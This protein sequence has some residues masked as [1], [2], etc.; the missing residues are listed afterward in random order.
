MFFFCLLLLALPAHGQDW[1]AAKSLDA[2]AETKNRVMARTLSMTPAAMKIEYALPGLEVWRAENG[3]RIIAGKRNDPS[4]PVRP[5]IGNTPHRSSPGLPVLPVVPTRLALP[6]GHELDAIRVTPGREMSLPG[7]FRVAHGQTSY[8]LRPGVR[9]EKTE[10]NRAV[11]ESD[12]PFPGK[13]YDIAG[14]HKKRGVSLLLVNLHPVVYRPQSG[15]L[16]W[17]DTM[18]VTVTTRPS[19]GA[20]SQTGALPYK[21]AAAGQLEGS[22]EN[23]EMIDSYQAANET[24]SPTAESR[25]LP[26]SEARY[27]LITSQ[28]IIDDDTVSPTVADFMAHRQSQ[29]LSTAVVS[30][31]SILAEP[32][33][34][35]RDDAETLRNFIID[36]YLHRNTEYVL[37]GGDVNIIPLRQLRCRAGAYTEEI[38]SD[39]YYQ[40][41]DGDFNSDGDDYWGEPTDGE[42]GGDVDLMAEIHVGRASAE[43][44]AELSN[45]FY[46]TM[47]YEN[48]AAEASY[49]T[50]ALMAGEWLGF[51][52]ISEYGEADLEEIRLGSSNHDYTTA[53][54]AAFPNFTVD[55]LYDSDTYEWPAGDLIDDIDSDIY[56]IIVHDGHGQTYQVMK[57]YLDDADQLNNTNP[58]FGYSQACLPGAF[59][60]DC[61]AEHLTTST[62]HGMFAGVYNSR[63]GW[64]M[65]N[66]TD[67]AS[68]RLAR[69]FWDACFGEYLLDLGAINTDSHEDNLWDISDSYV[70]WCIYE[71]NLL[72][73][74]CTVLRGRP[75][76]ALHIPENAT[77]GDGRLTGA[78]TVFSDEP[79]AA[80]LTVFLVSSDAAKVSVPASV[81]LLTGEKEVSFDL[82]VPDDLVCDGLQTVTITA[83]AEGF[84]AAGSRID[85]T[86]TDTDIDGDGLADDLEMISCTDPDDADTDD[87]GILDGD[88]DLNSNGQ[89]D[90]G[91]TDPCR[92]D[93][94][95]DGI[96]DGTERGYTSGDPS[97]TDP[98]VFQPDL[99]PDTTTDPLNTDTDGDGLDDGREDANHNGRVDDGETDPTVNVP[100][101]A[102]AGNNQ[103]VTEGERVVLDGTGSVDIDDG[104]FSYAWFQSA[105]PDVTLSDSR[106]ARSFFTAPEDAADQSLTFRLNVKDQSGQLS[107]DTCIIRIQ[108]K[109][110][111][112]ATAAPAAKGGGGGGGG[113]CFL[114]TVR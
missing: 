59:D 13:L 7:N 38:P 18:T 30:M 109:E 97:D 86:D 16:S 107:S 68:Q 24:P 34:V 45:F 32:A 113:G 98:D 56:G 110:T 9:P 74:P 41:L 83:D 80:D 64:G 54:F 12:T 39:L 111:T 20:R 103:T 33:Y 55:T 26:R 71:S 46:K 112:P 58:I 63:E 79:V 11:Y 14:V 42:D 77:E 84:M 5:V 101:T 61:I 53:G 60:T 82:I 1:R 73:D 70:R 106:T 104:I 57:L 99:D 78:G 100:P 93:T 36:A 31:E 49:L 66:S 90:E 95:G 44:A 50:T 48:S 96:Q 6:A 29:G 114:E 8:P 102:D 35:G 23:P 47:A 92:A 85:I 2:R 19:T 108:E 15:R 67:S 87:D 22:V 89:V 72:G 51:G 3:S 21:P 40:C 88:E 43:D 69:Q 65:P 37:L 25:V 27:A 94:D 10:K 17:Y 4:D 81:T 105:G 28:A 91:E 75:A 62:R 52:G 76:L